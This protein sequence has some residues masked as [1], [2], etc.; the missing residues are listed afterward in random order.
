MKAPNINHFM[1]QMV[2]DYLVRRGA[3]YFSVSPGSRSAPLT[4]AAASHPGITTRMIVDE[5]AAAYYAVGVA[6]ATGNPA[7]AICTSGTAVANLFPATAEAYQSRLPLILLTADRPEELQDCGANQ[8]IDQQGILG[9]YATSVTIPAPG[10]AT[11]IAEVLDALDRVMA[12]ISESPV[13]INMQFREPLAPVEE[14]YDHDALT[15][16]AA[17]WH[18]AHRINPSPEN[19]D[20]SARSIEEIIPLIKRSRRGLIVAGPEL[21]F[22]VSEAIGR[23]AER[24]GW[25]M[26][27]DILSQQRGKTGGNRCCAYD[28]YVNAPDWAGLLSADMILHFGGLPTSKRFNQFL[29][30]HKGIPYIKIQ[31]HTRTIDPGYLETKRII[32]SVGQCVESLIAHLEPSGNNDYL[33][34]WLTADRKAAEVL[35]RCFDNDSLAEPSAAFHIG[36]LISGG[37]ALYLSNSMPV[38]DADSFMNFENRDIMVGCNR[39][40]S[41]IDGVLASACGFAAGN[42]RRTM[43]LIGD[44]AL[45]HD[46]NSLAIAAEASVP[47]IIIVIN[48]HGGGIFDFLPIAQFPDW[49]EKCFTVSHRLAFNEAAGMFGLSYHKA[50]SVTELIAAC[51]AACETQKSSIM[52]I[53]TDRKTNVGEHE[54]IRSTVQDELPG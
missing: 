46:L 37:A 35:T 24:L 44:L 12:G 49:L 54:R 32:A 14:T 43:L 2:M 27:C 34:S 10:L 11:N 52:E 18:K 45:L 16:E 4:I 48:N 47:V 7:G 8:T 36:R 41:G 25:P 38:R 3:R 33:S 20:D 13:H 5:R 26:V 15:A 31:D 29:A 42:G 39:G 30:Q 50:S 23:L 28:L 53:I 1:A 9:R 22:R 17:G 19:H 21:P 40:A 6:R 51:Q